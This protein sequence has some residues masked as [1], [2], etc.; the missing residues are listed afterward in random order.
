M[1]NQYDQSLPSL[2]EEYRCC[3]IEEGEN[4]NVDVTSPSAII[5]VALI[6]LRSKKELSLCSMFPPHAPHVS[7]NTFL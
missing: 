4:V 5:A 6:Y 3:H 1:Y 7:Q 2:W